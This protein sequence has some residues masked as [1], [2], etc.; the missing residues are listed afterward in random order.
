MKED[1]SPVFNTQAPHLRKLYI[2]MSFKK[3]FIGD[4]ISKKHMISTSLQH[5]SLRALFDTP[6]A[7][8]SLFR[9]LSATHSLFKLEI[10]YLGTDPIP[11][12]VVNGLQDALLLPHSSSLRL[13]TLKTSRELLKQTFERKIR[14]FDFGQIRVFKLVVA[15][16]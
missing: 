9:Q 15:N 4:Q 7:L 14:E 10:E 12:Q 13:L 1:I 5:L 6:N 16:L 2:D 3:L 8:L 11:I